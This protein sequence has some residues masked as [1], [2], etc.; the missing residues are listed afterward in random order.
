[1][2][3]GSISE[4]LGLAHVRMAAEAIFDVGFR[5]GIIPL[6]TLTTGNTHGSRFPETLAIAFAAEWVVVDHQPNT[7]TGASET[8]PMPAWTFPSP[9]SRPKRLT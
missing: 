2:A 6:D 4:I 5:S 7:G 8:G 9:A 3:T 1:M